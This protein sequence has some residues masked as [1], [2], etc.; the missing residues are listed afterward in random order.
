MVIDY[1]LVTLGTF[2]CLLGFFKWPRA[3]WDLIRPRFI[4]PMIFWAS[5]FLQYIT[6]DT[7]QI[8]YKYHVQKDTAALAFVCLCVACFWIGFTPPIGTR[9]AQLLRGLPATLQF[10]PEKLRTPGLIIAAV[11]FFLSLALGGTA[12][13][14]APVSQELVS[15]VLP[16]QLV[17]PVGVFADIAASIGAILI[18]LA[19][20]T[21]GRRNALNVG[22]SALGVIVASHIFMARFSRGSGLVYALAFLAA[23]LRA[24][25]INWWAGIAVALIMLLMGHAGLTGRAV[26]GHFSGSFHYIRH[27]FTYSIF[28]WPEVFL[29]GV[30]AIDSLKSLVVM[31]YGAE[32]AEFGQLT[33]LQ[34]LHNQIPIPR[35]LGLP[36]VTY[37]ATTIVLQTR[38]R[39]FTSSMWGDAFAHFGYWGAL[40]FV[41]VGI[42]YRFVD[43]LVLGV[44]N[45]ELQPLLAQDGYAHPPPDDTTPTSGFAA[46]AWIILLATSYGAILRGVFN[47]FRAWN[48]SFFYPLYVLLFVLILLKYMRPRRY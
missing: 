17:I 28:N 27:L 12:I 38:T 9:L 33:R 13:F 19:W 7:D 39:G 29:S 26:Y 14:A 18:G 25:R 3:S 35:F 44:D 21:K 23:S 2:L 6:P 41:P 16:S 1:L 32:F 8:F 37:S 24:R 42:C 36:D 4:V 30:Y 31:M 11:P 20:P 48:T 47:S 15:S 43:R 22:L 5:I 40:T 10:D 34:W 46:N 45:D